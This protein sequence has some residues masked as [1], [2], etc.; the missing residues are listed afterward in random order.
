MKAIG[1][2]TAK[3]L[4]MASL[5]SPTGHVA[6]YAE[7]PAHAHIGEVYVCDDKEEA[8]ERGDKRYGE[9]WTFLGKA[10]GWKETSA[11]KEKAGPK[12]T[13]PPAA[14]AWAVAPKDYPT[15]SL[16]STLSE[17]LELGFGRGETLE[18]GMAVV[19][20]VDPATLSITWPTTVDQTQSHSQILIKIQARPAGGAS[21]GIWESEP[22]NRLPAPTISSLTPDTGPAGSDAT[23]TIAGTGFDSGATVNVGSAYGLVPTSQS[24]TELTVLIEAVNIAEAGTLAVSV[25]NSDGLSSNALSFTVT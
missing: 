22:R 5:E 9:E 23:V 1:S 2:T 25:Q 11:K 6:T 10:G 19:Q 7:L 17:L 21:I 14:Q 13:K 3:T 15:L 18:D 20:Y 12:P 24:E 8:F 16:A 4:P